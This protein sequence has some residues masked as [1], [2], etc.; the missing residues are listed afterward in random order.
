M[1]KSAPLRFNYKSSY[2]ICDI[3]YKN[4]YE[5]IN[6]GKTY[7]PTSQK[8]ELND[9]TAEINV[10]FPFT[11]ELINPRIAIVLNGKETLF[12]LDE[13]NNEAHSS[14]IADMEIYLDDEKIS[15]AQIQALSPEKIASITV[16]KKRN[17]MIIKSKK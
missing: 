17:L 7:Q 14:N 13:D 6:N 3:N 2:S 1:L 11:E 15:E 4:S 10:S 8:F 5:K 16:D 12:D 9:G